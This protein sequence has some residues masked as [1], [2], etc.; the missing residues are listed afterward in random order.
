MKWD[1][2][3]MQTDTDKKI[4][5]IT[6]NRPER[7]NALNSQLI[8]ELTEALDGCAAD[9][10]INVVVLQG[11]PKFFCVGADISE[12]G[13]LERA[14]Q[15]Y[16]YLDRVR[17]LFQ[18]IES[19]PKP[20]IAAVEGYA[21]GGGCELALACDLRIAAESAKFGLPEIEIGAIPGAGG[22]SR[23]S[24]VVGLSR[25]KEMVFFGERI[26]AE[27]AYRIGLV[28][29]VFPV[30]RFK[31]ETLSYAHKLA[32]KPTLAI[33]FSKQAIGL[34]FNLDLTTSRIL[35][36]FTGSIVHDTEDRREGM[37]AFLEKRKPVFRG[38]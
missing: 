6:L 24:R 31:E 20:V 9:Q 15:L 7:M 17:V 16:D 35:E 10:S 18:K 21:V 30:D 33:R 37:K 3:Q 27:E 19:L 2:I 32:Q 22:T 34:A 1:T 25:A 11:A 4:S 26:S 36:I 12:V 8:A 13:P 23:L 28:N 29:K 14:G 38:K 5:F